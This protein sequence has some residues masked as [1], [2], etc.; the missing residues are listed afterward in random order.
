MLSVKDY[1]LEVSI[2]KE[3]RVWR[4]KGINTQFK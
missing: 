2:Q 4:V 1:S 3:L